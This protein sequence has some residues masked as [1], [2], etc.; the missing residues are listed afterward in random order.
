MWSTLAC[1][2]HEQGSRTLRMKAAAQ[3]TRTKGAAFMLWHL[4]VGTLPS[5]SMSKSSTRASATEAGAV[6]GP[7]FGVLLPESA[8]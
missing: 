5:F 8:P 1:R 6:H 7:R 4:V 3:R 2:K